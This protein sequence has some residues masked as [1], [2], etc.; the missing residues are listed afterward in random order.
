MRALPWAILFLATVCALAFLALGVLAFNQHFFDLDH[1]AH[2]MVRAG[3][4]PQLRPLMQALSRIGSGYVLMPLTILAYW[5]LR[6]HGHRAA[7]WVPGML[8]GAF[9]VFALAKWIVA[10]PR[11]KLSPYGFPSAHTF[12]AV[13]FFGGVIYALWTIE[14]RPLWRWVGTIGMLLLIVGVAVSRLYLRSHWL[15]DV[16]GGVT[17]GAAYLLF[18]LMAADPR[19]R[20]SR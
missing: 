10:R 19:L 16:V 3:I 11:P 12:G 18:F 4:Y 5:L 14:M 7:R 9:V 13:V 1:S 15:S 8:A 2:D 20:P 17:G 6:R